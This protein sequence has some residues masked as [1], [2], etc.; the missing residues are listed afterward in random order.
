M[1]IEL[2]VVPLG[3]GES[4]SEYVSGV[5]DL[6][7]RSGLAYR[8]NPMGTVIEGDWDEVMNLVRQCHEKVLG[9]GF[10]TITTIKI[11]DRPGK[12]G[13]IDRKIASMEERL[14]RKL[15]K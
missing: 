5:L 2:S 15:R 8:V 1:L 4:V 13:R 7:D 12:G 14:E 11:D 6:I 10:R 9:Q 3:A